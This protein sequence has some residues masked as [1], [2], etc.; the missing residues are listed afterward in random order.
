M[1]GQRPGSGAR[2]A[3]AAYIALIHRKEAAL[4]R[5]TVPDMT[6]DGCIKAITA[7]VRRLDPAAT[8]AADLPTHK[9]EISSSK[10]AADL[11]AAIDDAGFTAQ[12]A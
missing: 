12:A 4:T 8:V 10:P 6:C 7:A 2:I 5:F 1:R 11:A 3:E 9:V